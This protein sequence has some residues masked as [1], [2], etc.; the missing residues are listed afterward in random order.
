M[1]H[2]IDNDDGW[3]PIESAPKDGTHILVMYMHIDTQCVFNAFWINQ[4]DW[5]QDDQEGWWSYQHSEVSRIKLE[6][7][8]TP[9]HWM[10]LPSPPEGD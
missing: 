5:M 8:M 10:P 9:T 2:A 4:E 7:F 1:S 6:D 3:L